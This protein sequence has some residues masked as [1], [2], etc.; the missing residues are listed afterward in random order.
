MTSRLLPPTCR[1]TVQYYLFHSSGLFERNCDPYR[2][3]FVLCV[4]DRPTHGCRPR[5]ASLVLLLFPRIVPLITHSPEPPSHV[6]SVPFSLHSMA[7]SRSYVLLQK[8]EDPFHTR[9]EDLD[10]L[11]AFTMC[12]FHF[13]PS[14]HTLRRGANLF[15]SQEVQPRSTIIF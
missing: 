14:P 6:A 13:L 10:G 15:F 11:T 4:N 8:G 1:C 3:C 12:A 9:F 7:T 2:I 5:K